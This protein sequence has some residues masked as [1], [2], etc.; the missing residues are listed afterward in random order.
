[1]SELHEYP[2]TSYEGGCNMGCFMGLCHKAGV[3]LAVVGDSLQLLDRNNFVLSQVKIQIAQSAL[4]DELGNDITAYII[5]AGTRE[6]TVVLT[7]GNGDEIVITVPYATK[8]TKDSE[9]QDIVSYLRNL[10]VS[11]DK[12]RATRG[13]GSAF[14]ITVPYATKAF[15]DVNDKPLTTYGASL[16]VAGNNVI[17]K[18][19]MGTIIDTITVHYAERAAADQNGNNIMEEYGAVLQAGTTTIKL[20]SKSGDILN[21]ITVPYST[22]SLQDTNGNA[23]LHDYAETLV[24]DND[25]KRLDLL[26]HDG[27]LLSSITVPFSTLSTDA[28]NAIERAE[29]VGDQLVL[30]TY[31]GV[32][33]RLTI[34]YAIRSLNDGDSNEITKTYVHN[35]VQ[36][37]VTGEITFYDAEGTALC[38]LTP[39]ARIAEY[40]TYNNLIADYIKTLVYDAQN[41]YLVVTHG[42]GTSE[43]IVIQYATKAWK[44]T[45][46]NI[47]K[48]TYVAF[49]SNVQANDGWALV[50]YNGE[51]SEIFRISGLHA[52]YAVKDSDGDVIK[53]T[54][55]VDITQTTTDVIN[56]VNKAGTV[57]GSVQLYNTYAKSLSQVSDDVLKLKDKFDNE[58]SSV[59]LYNTYG[60]S[61]NI[62]ADEELEL[63]DKFGTL[64][65]KVVLPDDLKDLEVVQ[66]SVGKTGVAHNN[67]YNPST[68]AIDMTKK[69]DLYSTPSI[70]L[71]MNRRTG[72]PI[73]EVI[74]CGAVDNSLADSTASIIPIGE[75]TSLA[76][77]AT[78]RFET[79]QQKLKEYFNTL[80]TSLSYKVNGESSGWSRCIPSVNLEQI[81]LAAANGP[82]ITPNALFCIEEYKQERDSNDFP[83]IK[84]YVK[85]TNEGSNAKYLG[86][87]FTNIDTTIEG[88]PTPSGSLVRAID[89]ESAF[90]YQLTTS[91]NKANATIKHGTNYTVKCYEYDQ[92]HYGWLE[93]TGG[94]VTDDVYSITLPGSMDYSGNYWIYKIELVDNITGTSEEV[95]FASKYNALTLNL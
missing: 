80:W 91:N 43:T 77:G 9:N 12:L 60:K 22:M 30:T 50:F 59:Q 76:N 87:S 44:D 64:L 46:G 21:E 78:Q 58:L 70:K 25:G 5:N 52:E 95:S 86:V 7:K 26:A 32:V 4:K 23:F 15:T 38:S 92:A 63:N 89:P 82:A 83:Y 1:M 57:L 47:I 93:V 36:D 33:T 13:D 56:L 37:P 42:T 84:R 16:E 73:F 19:G 3:K 51:G 31:G 71:W 54:Y 48:N 65:N 79:T 6:D 2:F 18:D 94:T 40:D 88:Y 8:A 75:N 90:I 72:K 35:V 61:L 55:G 20:I 66:K 49:V 45:Q 29:I 39:R 11:G 53:D 62:N 68:Q 10:T 17:L 27:T 14:E 74:E 28:T 24:V 81:R 69:I 41:D 85:V 67:M 34:P